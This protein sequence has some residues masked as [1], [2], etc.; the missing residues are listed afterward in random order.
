[1]GKKVSYGELI[2]AETYY[3]IRINGIVT[4]KELFVHYG[5]S[6]CIPDLI[7]KAI[8][9][10]IRSPELVRFVRLGSD[11]YFVSK[12]R[13]KLPEYFVSF[14]PFPLS[15]FAIYIGEKM[16]TLPAEIF[17]TDNKIIGNW[18][19]YSQLAIEEIKKFIE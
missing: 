14:R 6:A 12:D 13:D 3:Y 7:D 18:D 10:L 1:M 2:T 5:H 15:M 4:L 11:S 16:Y 17:S 19:K 9:D 8:A